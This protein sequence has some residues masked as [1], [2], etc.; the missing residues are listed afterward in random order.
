M[1]GAKCEIA[2]DRIG[3]SRWMRVGAGGSVRSVSKHHHIGNVG[4]DGVRDGGVESVMV[5]AVMVVGG[6]VR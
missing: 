3:G 2:G 1:D 5:M 4:T 6:G